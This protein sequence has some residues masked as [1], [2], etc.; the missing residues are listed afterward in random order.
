MQIPTDQAATRRHRH[1]FG[2]T[3]EQA[4]LARLAGTR[5]GETEPG[6]PGPARALG[7]PPRPECRNAA[8]ARAASALAAG[9]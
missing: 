4:A 5:G 8:W 6:R 1:S 7:E 3:A 9:G 2:T